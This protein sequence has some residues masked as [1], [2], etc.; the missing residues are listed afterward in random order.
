MPSLTKITIAFSFRGDRTIVNGT[1]F[2]FALRTQRIAQ[3]SDVIDL[4]YANLP[5][6]G[7][8]VWIDDD[9]DGHWI[10]V[11]KQPAFGTVQEIAPQVLDATEGYGTSVAQATNGLAAMVGSAR[12]GFATGVERGG[13]YVYVRSPGVIYEPA[14]PLSTTQDAILQLGVSGVRA[15]GYSLDFGDKDWAASGAPASLGSTGQINNGYVATIYRDPV[16]ALPGTNPYHLWQLLTTPGNVAVDQGQF[17]FSVAVSRDERWMYVGAPGVNEAYAYGRVTWQN[18][19]LVTQQDGSTFVFAIDNTIQAAQDQQIEVQVNNINQTLNVDYTVLS[20]VIPGVGTRITAVQFVSAPDEGST[21]RISRRNTLSIITPPA[22]STF[23]IGQYLYTAIN[24]YSF[25]VLVEGEL[26]RPNI[27][28]TFDANT[29]IISF[30]NVPTVGDEIIVR[31]QSYWQYVDTLAVPGMAVSSSSSTV[32]LGL[33]NFSLTVNAGLQ[34]VTDQTMRVEYDANNFFEG[35]VVSYNNSTGALTVVS[36]SVTGAGTYASW[37]VRPDDRFGASVTCTTDGRQ[38]MIGAPQRVVNGVRR[39]GAVYVFDRDVQRF[40][41]QADPSTIAFLTLGTV[42]QPVSVLVNDQFLTQDTSGVVLTDASNQFNVNGNT[43]TINADLVVGDFIDIETNQFRLLQIIS[44]QTAETFSNYGQSAEICGYNCSLYVGA[45][46]SSVQVFKGGVVQRQV[47]QARVYGTI[48]SQ[49]TAPV[50][51][52]GDTLRVNNQDIEIPSAIGGVSSLQGLANAINNEVPNVTATVSSGRLTLSVSNR[53]AAVE[54]NLLQVLP[55][56]VGSA[57]DTLGFTVYEFTQTILSP[58]PRRLASFGYSIGVSDASTQIIVGAPNGNMYIIAVFDDGSA[59]FDDGAT[60]FYSETMNSGAV[61]VYDFAAAAN[62]TVIN[63]DKFVVSQQI[64]VPDIREL[65]ALGSDVDYTLG[66]LYIAAPGSDKDD[67]PS[68]DSTNDYG[69]VYITENPNSVSG[70]RTLHAQQPVVDIRLL[71]SVFLYDLTTSAKTEFLD[72]FDPLQGKILGAARQNIDYVGAVDPAGY[73]SGAVNVRG[74]TWTGDQVGEIWWDTSTVRF[75]DPNQ[76]DI[77]Y[78]A[79]RWGQTFPGSVISV[80]QWTASTVPPSQYT[81][82]G[83]VRDISSYSVRAVLQRDGTIITEYFFWVQGV[84]TIAVSKGKTLSVQAIAQYID[85]PRGSGISYIAPLDSS[86]V[87]IYNCQQL[88]Q[89]QDTVLHIEFDKQFTNDNVHVEYQLVPQDRADGWITP[90]IYRK[91]QD[92]L[93]GV[94]EIGNLVP[95]VF[96]SPPERYGVQFRPRQ[97]MFVDRFLALKNF[98]QRSNSVMALYPITETRRF[99]LLDSQDPEPTA[100]SGIWNKRVATIEILSFQDIYAV[101][102][103]Y[104]YLVES[105][106]T[107]QGLWT[108]YEVITG[109]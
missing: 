29:Q 95:D 67:D 16:A 68:D 59:I 84:T 61:Y 53:S 15:L 40:V 1:G 89:A 82:P 2:A 22:T 37:M 74:S 80:Y 99:V 104:A 44:Q 108:V 9:G 97:S 31:A 66:L 63:P 7:A 102:L 56:S 25:S 24:I 42:T 90:I 20:S 65:D 94:D 30:I 23:A 70:W 73:N 3:F 92:S 86:T 13:I 101:P 10:V 109:A 107:Q 58:Y 51:T 45:P 75:I 18:Q 34:Y 48:T 28:Y 106:A 11:E 93:C 21:I 35:Y 5:V 72:F 27:D 36:E 57:F 91:L 77:V 52:P 96:L 85:N 87:A 38:V 88:I 14:S 55:G 32:T 105:D 79:R 69:R 50:L 6:P 78:A 103:G 81:G 49:A 46:Q 60:D 76:D 8:R 64:E 39:A 26:Q 17:G 98:V 54:G 41:N 19:I 43:V 71:N 4:P 33:G 100:T 83:T 62:A 47:N 12:L